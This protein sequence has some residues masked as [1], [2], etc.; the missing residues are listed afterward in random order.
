MD[1]SIGEEETLVGDGA[2]IDFE[3][4]PGF[5][6]GEYEVV[7]F[8]GGGGMGRVYEAICLP[9]GERVALKFLKGTLKKNPIAVEG[10][11][12]QAEVM[13][14]FEHPCILSSARFEASDDFCWLR[15]ELVVGFKAG[16]VFQ[17]GVSDPEREVVSLH[18]LM[19]SFDGG[20]PE[21]LVFGILSQILSGI[22]Y[23]HAKGVIHRDL[24]PSNILVV[25]AY[26]NIVVPV[27][28]KISDFDL[29]T[30]TKAWR[31]AQKKDPLS[32]EN[33]WSIGE[34]PTQGTDSS[35]GSSGNVVGTLEYMS[36]E[37]RRGD[38]VDQRTDLYAIG[39][40]AYRL[41]TGRGLGPVSPSQLIPSLN[42]GWDLFVKTALEEKCEER[43]ESASEMLL[44]LSS[45]E[46]EEGADSEI[47]GKCAVRSEN[48]PALKITG[49]SERARVVLKSSSGEVVK[50]CRSSKMGEVT[51]QELA[52]GYYRLLVACYGCKTYFRFIKIYSDRTTKCSIPPA[53][54][55]HGK[56]QEWMSVLGEIVGLLTG[57]TGA[58]LYWEVVEDVVVDWFSEIDGT[59]VLWILL[60]SGALIGLVG[61]SI[62]WVIAGAIAGWGLWWILYL[63]GKVVLV[64][65]PFLLLTLLVAVMVSYALRFFTTSRHVRKIMNET[66]SGGMQ[67]EQMVVDSVER[68]YYSISRNRECWAKAIVVILIA[69]I[70]FVFI[71]QSVVYT[72]KV[73]FKNALQR[74]DLNQAKICA[75]KLGNRYNCEKELNWLE[76]YWDLKDEYEYRVQSLEF[77]LEKIFPEKWTQV[78]KVARAADEASSLEDAVQGYIVVGALL[79]K[80]NEDLE[81]I[82]TVMQVEMNW[83][84]YGP[85]LKI[86]CSDELE[87]MERELDEIRRDIRGDSAE[88]EY[89]Q[90]WSNH[91]KNLN[92]LV[93]LRKKKEELIVEVDDML[94]EGLFDLLEKYETDSF[95]SIVSDYQEATE[96]DDLRISVSKLTDIVKNVKKLEGPSLC[97]G[98]LEAERNGDYYSAY[99]YGKEALKRTPELKDKIESMYER[100]LV[101]STIKS[102]SPE[103]PKFSG[104]YNVYVP[105]LVFSG[106]KVKCQEFSLAGGSE[107]A[108]ELQQSM[109]LQMHLPLEVRTPVVRIRMRFI[110]SGLFEMGS[111]FFENDRNKDEKKHDVKIS[112]P[113]YCGVYEITEAEWARVMHGGRTNSQLPVAN[114]SWNECQEFL[115]R[116]CKL[117]GVPEG[118]YSLLSEEEWEYVCRSG[119]SDPFA[120]GKKLELGLACFDGSRPYGNGLKSKT[121]YASGPV[122]GYQ[123]NAWGIYDM[124]GNV[125]EWCSSLYEPY[126]EPN[127]KSGEV[128]VFR[129]GSWGDPGD[130]CRS[131]WR[132]NGVQQ[133]TSKYI[134]LRIKRVIYP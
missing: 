39:I 67:I 4:E 51:V 38:W 32:N 104:Y 45:V 101:A 61:K 123:S 117:E 107:Q 10:L 29:A 68:S 96:T 106:Y 91:K 24:K 47:E 114:V 86:L 28:V 110:P 124:H 63:I 126:M 98:A 77:V 23:S 20:L 30:L 85:Q 25:P 31:N 75:T 132:G 103:S 111:P 19:K 95:Y 56:N 41:L 97:Y 7:R 115:R 100:L 21:R 18:D 129:G 17:E 57:I 90:F 88:Q 92:L 125:S 93:E 48:D 118:T 13:S 52:P 36:P 55:D 120:F 35:E 27:Q 70:C 37:Q 16:S 65:S 64:V 72:K 43:Y 116:L 46:R 74:R 81:K 34:G 2:T 122:G 71:D 89:A 76:R 40:L 79:D 113:F 62:L 78:H 121:K 9:T 60:I 134:G 133:K 15:M 105:K 3:L 12:K 8:L 112:R 119:T 82:P 66:V 14:R 22:S 54:K 83:S 59:F 50:R 58:I 73:S 44:A 5:R 53:R 84:E 127:K 26:N 99:V 130:R 108:L 1:H 42:S 69:F 131:A 33:S 11:R 6:V 109:A 128:R 94:S 87:V 102:S 49:L 80:L